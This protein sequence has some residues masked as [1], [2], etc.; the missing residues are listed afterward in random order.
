MARET[1][2]R[3]TGHAMLQALAALSLILWRPTV[4]EDRG[5][6]IAPEGLLFVRQPLACRSAWAN[7]P[8]EALRR[9][10]RYKCTEFKNLTCA[11]DAGHNLGFAQVG[12]G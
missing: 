3:H 6:R 10:L 4:S 5:A 8:Y 1:F 11:R 2:W 9:S 7:F 12:G